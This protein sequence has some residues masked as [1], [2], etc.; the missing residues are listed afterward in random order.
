MQKKHNGMYP[1]VPN[2]MFPDFFPPV[3]LPWSAAMT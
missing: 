3:P 1:T 2:I